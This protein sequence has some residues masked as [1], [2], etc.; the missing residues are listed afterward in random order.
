MLPRFI[1]CAALAL[2]ALCQETAGA[3]EPGPWEMR[4]SLGPEVPKPAPTKPRPKPKPVEEPGV[5]DGAS[6]GEA[7]VE[8]GDAAPGQSP[9][10]AAGTAAGQ[11]PEQNP[12]LTRAMADISALRGENARLRSERENTDEII[13]A[14]ETRN[15]ALVRKQRES[16]LATGGGLVVL[17]VLVGFVL[18]RVGGRRRRGGFS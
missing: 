16:T 15:D 5:Q 18:S 7:R 14:A 2:C 4:P 9:I 12:A 11:T 6:L 3:V 1:A 17:G 13:H 10:P 8:A